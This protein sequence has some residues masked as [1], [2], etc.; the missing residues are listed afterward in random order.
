[1]PWRHLHQIQAENWAGRNFITTSRVNSL[2]ITHAG[3]QR[4]IFKSTTTDGFN[5]RIINSLIESWGV[6]LTWLDCKQWAKIQTNLIVNACCILQEHFQIVPASTR[7]PFHYPFSTWM[8]VPHHRGLRLLLFTISCVGSF[9]SHKNQNSER[10]VR[11]GPMV[12]CP[13]PRRLECLTICRC[14]NKGSTFSSVI[15]SLCVLVRLGFGPAISRSADQRKTSW[16]NRAAVI[17]ESTK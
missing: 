17:D 8:V 3:M 6:R 2:L 15:L 7:W 16:A 9:T 11:R 14:H 1:M 13:Y 4:W 12:F 10:A 5:F